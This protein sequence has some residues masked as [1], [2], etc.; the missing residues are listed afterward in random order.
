[1]LTAVILMTAMV[2]F[3]YQRRRN[4]RPVT[5]TGLSSWL[6]SVGAPAYQIRF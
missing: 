4:R 3:L 2:Q 5:F 6:A 1:M